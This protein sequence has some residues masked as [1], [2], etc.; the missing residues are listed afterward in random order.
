M[1]AQPAQLVMADVDAQRRGQIHD[2]PARAAAHVHHRPLAHPARDDA[3][4]R[5]LPVALQP[6]GAVP[7]AVIVVG[8]VHRVAQP[9][10]PR[11]R[12]RQRPAE[13]HEPCVRAARAAGHVMKR[14]LDH[15]PAP[16]V[17]PDQDLLQ[18][19]EVARCGPEALERLAAI[20]PKAARQVSQRQRQH[21][22]VGAVENVAQQPARGVHVRAAAGHVPR[23]DEH[24]GLVAALPQLVHEYRAVREVGV[25]RDDPRRRRR[26]EAGQEPA[27]EAALGLDDEARAASRG[28]LGRAVGGAAVGDDDLGRHTELV[29]HFAERGQEQ[30]EIL[31]FV[32][33]GDDNGDLRRHR[34]ISRRRRA[35]SHTRSP[36]PTVLPVSSSESTPACSAGKRSSE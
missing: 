28:R 15:P 7:G 5:A 17:G 2:D 33:R 12:A 34:V 31:A 6:D 14:H 27:P 1:R 4:A 19:I 29:Q 11:Q 10:H 13:L 36:T 9:P 8:R 23:G 25:H 35:S 30:L 18:E 20:H 3:M 26:R 21:A 22:R 24:V 16:G 32:Q